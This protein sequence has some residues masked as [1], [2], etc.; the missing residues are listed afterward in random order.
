M[1]CNAAPVLD[2]V[3]EQGHIHLESGVSKLGQLGMGCSVF[4]M[5]VE[6]LDFWGVNTIILDL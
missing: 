5:I 6:L 2:G 1:A 4:A 3:S